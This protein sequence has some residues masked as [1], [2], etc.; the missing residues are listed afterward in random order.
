[1]T[2]IEADA[3][4][5]AEI[6]RQCDIVVA[7]LRRQATLAGAAAGVFADLERLRDDPRLKD[8]IRTSLRTGDPKFPHCDEIRARFGWDQHQ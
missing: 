8:D 4:A 6:E 5:G 2:G 3:D 1:M 7:A